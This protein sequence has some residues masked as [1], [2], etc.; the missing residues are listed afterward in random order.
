MA[1]Y[2]LTIPGLLEEMACDKWLQIVQ[3]R[4]PYHP[5]SNLWCL[6][7]KVLRVFKKAP[8]D[9]FLLTISTEKKSVLLFHSK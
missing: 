1:I 3:H 6:K 9:P 7:T 4:G 8:L 2:T 5:Q